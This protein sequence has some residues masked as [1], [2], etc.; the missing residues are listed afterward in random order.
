MFEVWLQMSDTNIDRESDLPA[1]RL[2]ESESV[3]PERVIEAYFRA[4][5]QAYFE[6]LSYVDVGSIRF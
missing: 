4:S 2:T 3:L 1:L 5:L 6:W